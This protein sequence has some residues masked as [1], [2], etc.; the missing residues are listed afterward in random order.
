[1]LY[2]NQCVEQY[3]S[4]EKLNMYVACE[5]GIRRIINKK[6]TMDWYCVDINSLFPEH[7]VC[8]LLTYIIF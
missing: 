2:N 5:L 4:H 1:M 8:V 6:S 7:S 3:T